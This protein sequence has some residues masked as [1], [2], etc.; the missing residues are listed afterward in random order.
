MAADLRVFVHP[1]AVC[2]LKKNIVLFSL[3]A[4]GACSD[5]DTCM[6]LH[7]ILAACFCVK[8]CA[9]NAACSTK[10]HVIMTVLHTEEPTQQN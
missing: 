1:A 4:P 2:C 6:S 10:W 9:Q 5:F 3:H 8:R 7:C